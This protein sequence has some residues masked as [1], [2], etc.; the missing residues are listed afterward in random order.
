LFIN[1]STPFSK[2]ELVAILKFG[3]EELFK[4]GGDGEQDRKAQE[5]DIDEI[6]SR[7]ED[8]QTQADQ[9]LSLEQE[10]LSKFKVVI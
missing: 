7:A 10:L 6:L 3:A 1:S 8:Q 4:E 5:M 9:S 2:E